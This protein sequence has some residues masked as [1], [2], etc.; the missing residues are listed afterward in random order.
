MLAKITNPNTAINLN[1]S[2]NIENVL[3]FYFKIAPVY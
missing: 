3:H 1:T 2:V